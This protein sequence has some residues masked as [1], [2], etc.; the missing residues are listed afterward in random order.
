MQTENQKAART[1]NWEILRLKGAISHIYNSSL[2]NNVDKPI[3]LSLL[4]NSLINA[5]IPKYNDFKIIE[6][7]KCKKD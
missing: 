7:S 3:I 2:I 1:R 4:N 6:I 5:K